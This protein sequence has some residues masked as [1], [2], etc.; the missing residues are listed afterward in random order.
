MTYGGTV[1]TITP[2]YTG[3]V[4]GDTGVVADAPSP[5]AR[6]RPPARARWRDRPTSRSCSGA[7]DSNYTISYVDRIGDGEQ[8]PADGHRLERLHDL[9]RHGADDHPDYSGFV[10]GDT[11]ASLTTAADLLDHGHQLEPGRGLALPVVVHRSG[12]P[13]LHHHLRDGSVTVTKAPLTI[14]AS[15]GSMTYGGTVPTITPG[16]AGF[17]NG[18]TAVVAHHASR[19]ARPTAT[20]SSPV[21]GSALHRRRARARW[22]RTTPSA[23]WRASVTVTRPR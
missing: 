16:Y 10:N 21:S 22:T 3:F 15:S 17:V 9:R 18:D 13:E 14:T 12:R 8:G 4:N 20:S 6:P 2:G 19:P 1:P 7:A 11:A 5:P 23:T